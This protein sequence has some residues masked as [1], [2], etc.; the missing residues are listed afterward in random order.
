MA[1]V[2]AL[3]H[4]PFLFG[5]KHWTKTR[6][7]G[8]ACGVCFTLASAGVASTIRRIGRSEHTLTIALW[9]HT[10]VTIFTGV[11]ILADVQ[12]EVLPHGQDWL[13]L[14]AIALT[15]F[16]AQ[17]A[18]TRAL[19]QTA[20]AT[21]AGL[22]FLTVIYGH[23]LGTLVF[24]E[25]VTPGGLVGAVVILAGV[26]L[27]VLRPKPPKP[28]A[29]AGGAAAGDVRSSSAT[30][31]EGKT[32][33]EPLSA[34]LVL[35]EVLSEDVPLLGPGAQD[36][37]GAAAA[38]QDVHSKAEGAM[39]L[40]QL[41]KLEAAA[42][43]EALASS[44]AAGEGAWIIPTETQPPQLQQQQQEEEEEQLLGPQRGLRLHSSGS[45]TPDEAV[46]HLRRSIHL[47]E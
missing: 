1:G 8:M 40:V 46:P 12:E 28:C 3:A 18:T 2:V 47:E 22:N 7:L 25:A 5:G 41:A 27:V 20:V 24:H 23:V 15:T 17:L 13:L 19:Q 42:A 29:A 16:L 9:F 32:G 35:V 14:A 11:A 26:L 45:H 31:V 4:P 33:D 36:S 37:A 10:S 6:L 38:Q 21:V 43:Q 39:E 34:G 44:G 30:D